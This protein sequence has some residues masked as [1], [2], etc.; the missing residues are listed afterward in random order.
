MSSRTCISTAESFIKSKLGDPRSAQFEHTKSCSKGLLKELSKVG[1]HNWH[2]GYVQK[3]AVNAK[4]A[5]GGYV[6]F[7]QYSVLIKNGAVVTSCLDDCE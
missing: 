7:K 5:F 3:G 6:G 1:P 2:F 4:N